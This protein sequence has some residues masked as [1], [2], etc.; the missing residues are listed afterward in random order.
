MN[1]VLEIAGWGGGAMVGLAY[2][3]VSM[4]RI[5]A[6]SRIFQLL[7]VT[8]GALLTWTALHHGALSNAMIDLVWVVFG[9]YT[10]IVIGPRAR[11]RTGKKAPTMPAQPV[12]QTPTDVD[13]PARQTEN[14]TSQPILEVH[15]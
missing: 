10:L 7:N 4:G 11:K 15:R 8:G 12:A 5:H 6:Q 3:L 13:Y 9:L 2:A 14:S 1:V